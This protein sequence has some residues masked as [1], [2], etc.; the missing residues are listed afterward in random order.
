MSK[1]NEEKFRELV[2]PHILRCRAGDWEHAKRVVRWV[3]KLAKDRDDLDIIIKAAYIHDIGWRDLIESG[4]KI[5][6]NELKK[7]EPQANKNT[8]P[9][10]Q[11]LL[12]EFGD[13][14]KEINI[15]IQL[16]NAADL[17]SSSNR[18]EE[19]IVDSDNLSK[20]NIEHVYEKYV[21]DDYRKMLNLWKK[22]F[23]NRIQTQKG[24]ALFPK[25]LEQLERDIEEELRVTAFGLFGCADE[26]FKSFNIIM[27][28]EPKMPDYYRVKYYLLCHLFR[29]PTYWNITF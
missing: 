8:K 29:S 19:I 18:V 15:A 11:D 13:A 24:K 17:H 27:E 22:E 3:R 12:K 1:F 14:E 10:V 6:K 20:L 28:K 2:K 16:I 21:E 5:T 26:F 7:L 25:L 4:K 9:F 23:P